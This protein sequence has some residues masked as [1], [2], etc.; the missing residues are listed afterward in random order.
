MFIL[1]ITEDEI[2]AHF[3]SCGKI[4]SVR[5]IKHRKTG[6]SRGVG[7]INF[8]E[9]DSVTLALELNDTKL[10]N[11]Q[12]RVSNSSPEKVNKKRKQGKK[13]GPEQAGQKKFKTA[14]G[15][16]KVTVSIKLYFT[17]ILL[18]NFVNLCFD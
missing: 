14:K 13:P 10:K 15:E 12:I 7:Y 6:L 5:L 4:E 11:R 9:A 17:G 16:A 1:D 8:E 18:F 3:T 2:H